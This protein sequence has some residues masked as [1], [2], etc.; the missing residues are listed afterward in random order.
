M[1]IIDDIQSYIHLSLELHPQVNPKPTRYTWFLH[2][3]RKH[4]GFV[5]INTY[6]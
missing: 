6:S 4:H 3:S 2:A 1:I 5:G